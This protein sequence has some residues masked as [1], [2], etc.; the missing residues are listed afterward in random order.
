MRC[1]IFAI[2]SVMLLASGCATSGLDPSGLSQHPAPVF[3]L[4]TLDHLQISLS[5]FR[6]RV[7]VLDFWATW[8]APCR[9]GLPHL[10]A[11]AANS[12][13]AQRG[14]EVLAVN[15][16]EKPRTIRD[17]IEQNHYAFTVLQDADGSTGRGYRASAL[18]TTIVVGRDGRVATV[19][20]GWTA[21]TARQIDDAVTAALNAP[22][23]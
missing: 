13:M 6:G 3:S 8:C 10:A 15:E 7:V 22:I 11:L 12:G 1:G 19:I 16:E 4:P 20:G 23:P 9:E 5:N 2:L 14:L 21:D 17:F 18:P